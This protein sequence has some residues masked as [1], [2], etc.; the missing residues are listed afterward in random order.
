MMDHSKFVEVI[1]DH[2]IPLFPGTTI[3]QEARKAKVSTMKVAQ[4][5]A[6][7]RLALKQASNSNKQLVL[8][9]TH[10]FSS[11]E[12]RLIEHF[13]ENIPTDDNIIKSFG[14]AVFPAG[15][16]NAIA[17]IVSINAEKTIA[18]ILESF[19]I[20]AGRTYEGH[21]LSLG[22]GIKDA[23]AGPVH[24]K[25]FLK[26][27]FGLVLSDGVSTLVTANNR[28][29][30]HGHVALDLS[31]TAQFAPI[32]FSGAASWASSNRVSIV[33]NRN[34]EILVFKNRALIFT[35][36]RNRWQYYPHHSIVKQIAA[37]TQ[38]AWTPELRQAI[39]ESALDVSFARTGGLI[40]LI[41]RPEHSKVLDKLAH[42]DLPSLGTTPKASYIHFAQLPSFPKIERRV[43]KE[44]IAIDG[45][46]ILNYDGNLINF[47]AIVTKIRPAEDGGAR[48]AAAKSLSK[49]GIALKI[50]MDGEIRAYYKDTLIVSFA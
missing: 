44:L 11:E 33:L 7:S 28:G 1:R 26:N 25:D 2:V 37:K 27:D 29:F 9:R 14:T 12:R 34:G 16:R 17:S 39:Y 42:D 43:R 22:V 21:N 40:A 35:K 6:P 19:E 10:A 18:Q 31:K 45:A 49:N 47:G 8:Q 36:R 24:I 32:A 38:R 3:A 46:T 5:G 20:L 13:I 4:D 23:Q 30:V 50:S 15:I 48:T 41:K